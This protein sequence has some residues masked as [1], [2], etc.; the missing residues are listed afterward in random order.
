MMKEI[1]MP[2]IEDT[3]AF[4]QKAHEGQVDKSG[5]P[6][7]KHPLSVMRRLPAEASDDERHAALLHDVL[8]DTAYTAEDLRASGYNEAVIATVLLLSRPPG[9]TYVEWIRTIAASGNTAAIRIKI[10]DNE[11]NSDPAR[12][13]SLPLNEQGIVRRYERSLAILRAALPYT[14]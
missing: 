14:A 2:S 12:I 4:I 10:A 11:D 13:A 9:L 1:S 7:W 8:E 6:Y 3:I 5:V